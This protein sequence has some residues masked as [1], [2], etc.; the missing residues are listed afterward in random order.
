[1][2]GIAAS[3]CMPARCEV[4]FHAAKYNPDFEAVSASRAPLK[5]LKKAFHVRRG[6]MTPRNCG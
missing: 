6:G 3:S 1:M 5:L 2:T 4:S